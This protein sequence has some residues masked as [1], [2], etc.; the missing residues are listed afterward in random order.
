MKKIQIKEL[1]QSIAANDG[2]DDNGLKWISEKFSRNELKMFLRFL[3]K[4]IKDNKVTAFFGGDINEEGKNK[5]LSLFPNKKVVFKR[6]D[7]L[8]GAGIRIEYGDF[9]LDYSIS[10]IVKRILSRIRETI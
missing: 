7:N 6:D 9:V 2:I 3:S 5:V 10:G 4:E 1:A 8:V